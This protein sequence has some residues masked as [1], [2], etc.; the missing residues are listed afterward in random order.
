MYR[1]STAVEA[2]WFDAVRRTSNDDFTD[3]TEEWS[4]VSVCLHAL[5]HEVLIEKNFQVTL[6]ARVDIVLG[7]QFRQNARVAL[8]RKNNAIKIERV[9]LESFVKRVIEEDAGL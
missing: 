7:D 3:A 8:G 1:Q 6:L 5:E 2:F 9:T 4:G